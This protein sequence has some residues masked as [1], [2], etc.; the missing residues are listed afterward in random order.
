MEDMRKRIA[1]VALALLAAL[2]SA[3]V[4]KERDLAKT[5]GVLRLELERNYREQREFMRNY[6]VMSEGQHEQ[7]VE[8]MKR[9]EQI[10]L[11]LYSQRTDFT[12]D[13]AYAC[14]QATDLYRSLH[15]TNM[16]YRQTRERLLAE[17]AR[18]DSLVVAL[19]SLPPATGAAARAAEP[20]DS[21]MQELMADGADGAGEEP[22]TLTAQE[23]AD[24][25]RCVLYARALR[26]NLVRFVNSL[27]RD[28]RYYTQV[29][30]QVEKLNNYAQQRYADL[31]Q[32]IFVNG[33]ENYFSILARLPLH[34]GSVGRDFSD[35][36]LPLDGRA[37][38]S[39]WRGPVV[40]AVSVLM[41][42]YILLATML[43]NAV[44]RGVPWA[45]RRWAPRLAARFSA[46]VASRV[47]DARE[48]RL[49]RMALTLALGVALFAVAITVA[50]QFMT[51]DLFVMAAGLMINLA[52]L[53]EAIVLSLVV[54]LR[55]RQMRAGLAVYL[56]FVLMAFVVILFRILLIP[57]S[58]VNLIY[59]P[60]LLAFVVWQVG[61]QRARRDRLP[62]TDSLYAGISL[63]A[64]VVG[65]VLAWAGY[66][67]LAVQ[68]MIWWT[69]QLAAVQT[70]TCCYDVARMY[71]ERVMVKRVAGRGDISAEAEEKL[72]RRMRRGD[73][74]TATWVLDFV[75]KAVIPVLAVVSVLLSIYFAASIFEMTSIVEKVFFYNFIDSANLSKLSLFKL[76]V[77]VAFFFI[78]GYINYAVRSYYRHWYRR[79]KKDESGLNETLI[80]NVIAILVWGAYFWFVLILLRVP[81]SGISIVTAGLATGMGFAMKDLL[82]NFFYGISLMTGRVRVGDYIECDGVQGKVES[83]TYQSTQVATR[84][85]SVIAFLNASL[86]NKNFK[87]LTRNHGYELMK[88]AVGVAYGVSVAEVR[89]MLV[90]A[91]APMCETL[92]D[93]RR[94]VNPAQGISV[95][96]SDFGESSVDLVVTMW[97]LVDQRPA[98]SSRVREKIYETLTANGVEIPF[99]Q[100]DIRIRGGA[101]A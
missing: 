48:F 26:N 34:L 35:K 94:L 42:F 73:F 11:M 60:L 92:P 22:Y 81:K 46:R 17:I 67:L 77:V 93:G 2:P 23:Q 21:L 38:F 58:I 61:V 44:V 8:Y 6:E 76:C 83:I 18:Y 47:L 9:S 19:E 95:S 101:G 25:G 75:R 24:R 7:L 50:R 1:I 28:N 91:L 79:A 72:V 63:A 29:S 39:E 27:A 15:K 51:N 30:E 66:T 31:Q 62:L 55:G 97:V 59:P 80:R 49:K 87:N 52:W 84:D 36:Y 64:M 56:P 65:C 13:V 43:S 90:E 70:I 71:E 78:F 16:P 74:F 88:V 96:L 20:R 45:A 32:S 89:R 10:G 41:L 14:Q 82:E 100:R 12:F 53:V 99:P 40:W 3:A 57:N 69:F 54:R 33:G 5:L 37:Q 4:L 68:V 86:F 85:G 98:F